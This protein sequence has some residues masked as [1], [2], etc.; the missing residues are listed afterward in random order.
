LFLVGVV[1][2]DLAVEGARLPD[3]TASRSVW[4]QGLWADQAL[5]GFSRGVLPDFVEQM[6]SLILAFF[7]LPL[8]RLTHPWLQE[9]DFVTRMA[10]SLPRGEF[11]GALV[12][13]AALRWGSASET[14][15]PE[16]SLKKLC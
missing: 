2:W 12:L 8:L 1:S 13:L 3:W 6:A 9:T 10:G 11:T 5:R 4:V 15:S 14:E 7:L 16:R